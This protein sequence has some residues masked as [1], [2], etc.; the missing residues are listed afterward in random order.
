MEAWAVVRIRHRSRAQDLNEG[1]T[2]TPVQSIQQ[3]PLYTMKSYIILSCAAA[4]AAVGYYFLSQRKVVPRE[5]EIA[6]QQLLTVIDADPDDER[7]VEDSWYR[8]TMDADQLANHAYITEPSNE[9]ETDGRGAETRIVALR[10]IRRGFKM[11]FIKYWV[12]WGKAQFPNVWRGASTADRVCIANALVREMK[13]QSVRNADIVRVKDAIVLGICSASA[14]EVAARTMEAS[15]A[16]QQRQ[17]QTYG[18]SNGMGLWGLLG[19]SGTGMHF[20]TK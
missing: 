4:G 16:M 12:T 13:S 17:E 5:A 18:W 20:S 3:P 10:K 2:T 14:D 7:L 15:W 9:F 11:P 1:I 19:F 8:R 6:A